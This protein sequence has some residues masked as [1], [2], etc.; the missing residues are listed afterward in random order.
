MRRSCLWRDSRR[1]AGVG[2][3]RRPRL[4]HAER[5]QRRAPSPR[6]NRRSGFRSRRR[7]PICPVVD[8]VRRSAARRPRHRGPGEQSRPRHRRV[9]RAAGAG[10]GDRGQRRRYPTL[11]G[12]ANAVTLNSNRPSPSGSGAAV[13]AGEAGARALCRS[14]R[15]STSTR[16]GFDASWE[17]DLFGGTRRSIEEARANTDAFRWAERDTRVTLV[18][19]VANDYLTLRALQARIAVGQAELQ[20]QK[21]LFTLDR[22]AAE[23]RLRHQSRRQPAVDRSGHGRGPDPAAG[24]AGQG[25]GPRHR[26]AARPAAGSAHRPARRHRR[27]P[28]AT[29]ADPPDRPALRAPAPAARHPPSRTQARRQQRRDRRADGQPLSEGQPDRPGQLR[30]HVARHAVLA[31]EPD[32]RAVGMGSVPIFDAGRTPASIRVA[33]EEDRQAEIAYRTAIL[34]ALREVED[35]LARYTAE[36]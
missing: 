9:A 31:P 7:T 26:R 18:A 22:G 14:R 28:P 17:L 32:L 29:A 12:S 6:R 23:E 10:A 11:N 15:I 35:D 34:R 4:S 1:P 21:D 5:C 8:A 19:E 25:G 16:S 3:H 33:R 24:G 36:E 27:G 13:A 2:V 20:R 30:G